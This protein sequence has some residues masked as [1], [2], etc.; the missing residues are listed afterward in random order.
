[1]KLLRRKFLHLA[2]AVAALPAIARVARAQSY[3]TRPVRLVVG[4]APAGGNDIA[5]RLMGRW[6][7]ERLGKQFVVENRAGAA[8]NV[9]TEA[10]VNASPDGY[11]LLFVSTPAA[12]NATL[13]ER[14][15]FNFL[16][17]IVPIAGIAHLPSVLAVHPSV[18]AQT[19]PEF[20]A[21]A[22]NNPG[23]I[24]M[25]SA[26]VG[27]SGHL[28]GELFKLMTGTD[29]VHVP[30]RGNG[31]ALT[32]LLGG[33]VQVLFPTA[34]SSIEY[35]KAGKLRALGV[36]TPARSQTLPDVPAIAE[37]VPGYEATAWYGLGAPKGTP[38]E[39][40]D[41][42]AKETNAGLAD[43][44][45]KARFVALALEPMA[46]T[47]AEFATFI[48]AETAKWGKVIRAANIKVE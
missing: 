10:V 18:P 21:Y 43:P 19:V 46:M 12:I 31:P 32:D 37:F 38:G 6:L 11:T 23:K 34:P 40:I 16:R 27:S 28:S 20:I 42:L 2:A 9:A 14:L 44:Q 22:K 48:A 1:M 24:N 36:T 13:Y 47:S 26:G 30:Y 8:T 33:Q 7:S 15:K 3:P 5:A 29:L 17:D 35:I 25:A 41:R 39:I 4:F 45:L